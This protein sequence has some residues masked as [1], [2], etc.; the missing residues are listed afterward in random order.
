MKY[1]AP[2]VKRLVK[3]ID[4]IVEEEEEENY[5]IEYYE[6]QELAK[7]RVL[8]K[9]SFKTHFFIYFMVNGLIVGLNVL[10]TD[11]V[12]ESIFDVWA[13]WVITAWGL[14]LWI[15]SSIIVTLQI[16][17]LEHKIFA[18]TSIIIFYIGWFLVFVNYFVNHA[19]DSTLIWWPWPAVA[20][21]IFIAGYAW[22]V[23]YSENRGKLNVRISREMNKMWQKQGKKDKAQKEEIPQATNTNEK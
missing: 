7:I 16:S 19:T 8:L 23:F 22:I 12:I 5:P 15:H 21:V 6:L 20:F 2:I 11:A 10:G 18:I 14:I 9:S 4:D 3:E 1:T 13:L 17:N